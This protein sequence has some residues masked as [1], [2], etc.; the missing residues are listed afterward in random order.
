MCIWD[1]LTG[2]EIDRYEWVHSPKDSLKSI[3]FSKDE[4]RFFRLVPAVK[5]KGKP[6]SIEIYNRG[7]NGVFN[8][9]GSIPSIF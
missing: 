8:L 4:N 3:K 9:A 6:N 7:E 1:A 2:R 5:D